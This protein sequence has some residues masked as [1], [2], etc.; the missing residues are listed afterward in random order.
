MSEQTLSRR[1][2]LAVA[3]LGTAAALGA[4][5]ISGASTSLL[6]PTARP[7]PSPAAPGPY[8]VGEVILGEDDVAL[9]NALTQFM[10]L[11]GYPGFPNIFLADDNHCANG[12]LV[13]PQLPV[14]IPAAIYYP[15]AAGP[16]TPI[17][18][19]PVAT[20]DPRSSITNPLS[21]ARG[22]FPVVLYAHAYRDPL[23]SAC[24]GAHPSTRD[25]TSVADLLRHVA[26]Y[27][28]VVVVPDLSWI[29]GGFNP[30][31]FDYFKYG[32]TL[33]AQVLMRYYDHLM[34]LNSK[35]FA[36]Q[37]DLSRLVVAGH[38]TGGGAA[39]EAAR[40]LSFNVQFQSLSY[41]LIAPVVGVL[42]GAKRNLLV[43][44][45]GA[46]TLQVGDGPD[47]QYNAGGLPKT[48]VMIPGANHFGYTDICPANN[49]CANVFGPSNDNNG[50][51]G[52]ALQQ[53]A[54]ASYL[55]ALAR[56]YALGDTTARPYLTGE[57]QV[58]GLEAIPGIQV[59]AQG[60]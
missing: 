11:G 2:F 18:P 13:G 40:L 17:P 8:Q 48:Q 51:I 35:L 60:L 4:C 24:V 14:N 29:P 23:G 42:Y 57:K 45:G 21:I 54:G 38:S 28:C 10:T 49:N 16:G 3:G 22:P 36:G 47:A 12:A 15:S 56:Y 5:G 32:I 19:L 34:T 37:L 1:R 59:Q 27:G 44:K 50:D 33:R 39:V 20:R 52:R 26:S 41:G 55:A 7:N 58:E 46:D 9:H 53:L 43:V 6:T 31:T 30:A 25:F